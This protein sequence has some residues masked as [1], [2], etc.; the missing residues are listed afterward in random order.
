MSFTDGFSSVF[1]KISNLQNVFLPVLGSLC[2]WYFIGWFWF[3]RMQGSL[4]GGGNPTGAQL[5]QALHDLMSNKA[6]IQ[7]V[8]GQAALSQ[9]GLSQAALSQAALSQAGGLP[10]GLAPP[11]FSQSNA[12][13][14]ANQLQVT[15]A[16][17]ANAAQAGN[18][19]P[20]LPHNHA[21]MSVPPPG[22]GV[23]P[24]PGQQ[25]NTGN[26]DSQ[27]GH[28]LTTPC[29]TSQLQPLNSNLSTPTSQLQTLNSKL[30]TLN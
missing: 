6:A 17:A 24:V 22:L 26:Q 27:V 14:A 12:A 3:S 16:Q 7:A 13:A 20:G 28:S 18:S 23:L 11:L 5:E 8:T 10:H 4:G 21:N 9:A 29:P 19:Q 1:H 2:R 25:M 30:S 15:L